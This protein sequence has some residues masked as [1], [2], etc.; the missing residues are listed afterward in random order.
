[1]PPLEPVGEVLVGD[2][3]VLPLCKDIKA[4]VTAHPSAT[5]GQY[6]SVIMLPQNQGKN[7]S[8]GVIQDDGVGLILHPHLSP[9]Q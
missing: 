2:D 6:I 5:P 4:L 3:G 8:L 9:L 7:T 1:M